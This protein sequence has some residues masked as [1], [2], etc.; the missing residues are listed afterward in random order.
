[1]SIFS[2]IT[3]PIAP[4]HVSR[5]PEASY[6]KAWQEGL[7]GIKGIDNG[8]KPATFRGRPFANEP[9]FKI[10]AKHNHGDCDDG[11]EQKCISGRSFEKDANGRSEAQER[12]A[13]CGIER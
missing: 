7:S 8:L 9:S 12:Q 1:M 5:R 4:P 3:V 10:V 6:E 2:E 11:Q 13:R